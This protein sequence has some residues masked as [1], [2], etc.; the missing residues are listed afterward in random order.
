LSFIVTESFSG[1][2]S[3]VVVVVG[4]VV[5]V[6]VV[7]EVDVVV[8][9]V[10][11]VE[12]VVEV[13]VVVVEV[14]VEVDVVVVEVDDVVPIEA[15]SVTLTGLSIT[16]LY[17][18]PRNKNIPSIDVAINLFLLFIK[19]YRIVCSNSSSINSPISLSVTTLSSSK[20]TGRFNSAYFFIKFPMIKIIAI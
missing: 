12:V 8:V 20:C 11:V 6:E 18:T 14:V 13:D 16:L 4:I 5:V 10:D 7:V 15:V 17:D 19:I 2:T 3:T 1:L 9:E